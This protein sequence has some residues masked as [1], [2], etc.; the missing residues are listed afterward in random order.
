LPVATVFKAAKALLA[1]VAGAVPPEPVAAE[2]SDVTAEPQAQASAAE[3][4]RDPA[5]EEPAAPISEAPADV[6]SEPAG[7]ELAGDQLES[8]A[9]PD[10]D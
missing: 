2:A 6:S 7:E 10:R 8:A 4:A 9:Q 3:A 1:K 5:P